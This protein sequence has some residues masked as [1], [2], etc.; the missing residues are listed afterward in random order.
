M[1]KRLIAFVA[2]V[3]VAAALAATAAAT[4]AAPGEG[5]AY[6]LEDLVETT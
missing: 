4:P 1:H 3:A 5:V 2:A 6:F